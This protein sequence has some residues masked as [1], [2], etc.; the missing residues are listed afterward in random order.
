M[1]SP[2]TWS[3]PAN[4]VA[5]RAGAVIADVAARAPRVSFVGVDIEPVLL[6]YAEQHRAGRNVRFELADATELGGFDFLFSI[7]FVHHLPSLGGGDGGIRE[8]LHPGGRWLLI[9][10]NVWHPAITWAIE[11]MK[12]QGLD[13]D[14]FVPW[15]TAPAVRAA[16]FRLVRRRYMH[17]FPASA[18]SLSARLPRVGELLEGWAPLGASVVWLLEAIP[19][20]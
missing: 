3:S 20:K 14:H 1:S 15:L 4:S 13:E 6:A 18:S 17:L 7:D 9:E 16:G 5:R 12:R 10:P 8:A 19:P 2:T 11:R